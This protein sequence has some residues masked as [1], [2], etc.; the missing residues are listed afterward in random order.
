MVIVGVPERIRLCTP[1]R[2]EFTW[3]ISELTYLR[4]EAAE[5]T[6]YASLKFVFTGAL[7]P[8]GFGWVIWLLDGGV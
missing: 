7:I 6:N 3:E 2:P 8:P 4:G 1:F 5:E